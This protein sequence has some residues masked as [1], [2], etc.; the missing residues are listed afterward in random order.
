MPTDDKLGRGLHDLADEVVKSQG[1]ACS[2]WQ[3]VIWSAGSRLAF[4]NSKESVPKHPPQP[5]QH[6]CLLNLRLR[7]V[8][9][10]MLFLKLF[11]HL[12]LSQFVTG[13]FSL[14]TLIVIKL[15]SANPFTVPCCA[16]G[17]LTI[18]FST[19]ARVSPSKSDNFEFSG[20]IFLVSIIGWCVSTCGHHRW[21]PICAENFSSSNMS[22]PSSSHQ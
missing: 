4:V 18:I 1:G 10:R 6:T 14:L 12:N 13:R 5:N 15:E 11:H 20:W 19:I 16:G 21:D 7:K 22:T 17:R 9:F 2:E 3:R 8:H